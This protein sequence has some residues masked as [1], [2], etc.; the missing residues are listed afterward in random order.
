MAESA[1]TAFIRIIGDGSGLRDDIEDELDDL[2]S[3]FDKAGER[4]GK[5]YSKA[6]K[7]EAKGGFRDTIK[8]FDRVGESIGRLFGRGSRNNFLNFFGSVI[9]NIIK[10]MGK[11]IETFFNLG[12]L[13]K[14]FNTGVGEKGLSA[15]LKTM[16]SAA[17]NLIGTLTALAIAFGVATFSSGALASGLVLLSGTIIAL[18]GTIEFALIAAFAALGPIV[19]ALGAVI[20]GIVASIFVFKDA[21]GELGAAM[22]KVKGQAKAL[23]KVFKDAAFKNAPK[24]TEQIAE[25]MKGLKP[26]VEAAGRGFGAFAAQIVKSVTGPEFNAFRDAFAKFLPGAMQ[27]LGIIFGNVFEGLGGFLRASIPLANQ[28]LDWLVKITDNFSDFTNSKD[29]QKQIKDF[30]RDAADSAKSLG[31]FLSSAAGLV[32][33]LLSSGKDTGDSL[34]DSMADALDRVRK[35]LDDNPEAVQ[36][37]FRDTKTFAEQLGEAIEDIAN[38]IDTLDTPRTRKAITAVIDGLG[39][40]IIFASKVTVAYQS[41]VGAIVQVFIT[42]ARNT[43]ETF[44]IVLDAGLTAA[45]G[46]IDA[47]ALIPGPAG[48]AAR[49]IQDAFDTAS[50]EINGKFDALEVGLDGLEA[51]ANNFNPTM[52]INIEPAKQKLTFL[53]QL[54]A[55]I[56]HQIANANAAGAAAAQNGTN[57]GSTGGT[58]GGSQDVDRQGAGN[59][60]TAPIQINVQTPTTDPRAVAAE[61]VNRL[62]ALGY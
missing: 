59:R 50:D 42:L 28:L 2:D 22:D 27:K 57:T 11:L 12:D 23:F 31:D 48:S 36:N 9:T 13:I 10:T 32:Q 5:K 38:A 35:W 37:F 54:A 18:A 46:I 4:H 49:K 55:S 34:F 33:D 51:A 3:D 26:L 41:S 24:L 7:K 53:G 25:A 29:G 20:A 43:I 17:L 30:L 14:K 15:T 58:S 62:V 61:T 39:Q 16:Q 56:Q 47:L 44:K 60:R 45:S 6:F 8:E 19:I 1:G 40:I 52:D 21:T